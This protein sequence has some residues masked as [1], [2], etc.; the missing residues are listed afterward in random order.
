MPDFEGLATYLLSRIRDIVPTLLPGGRLVGSEYECASINGGQGKSFKININT[1]KWADFAADQQ[2]GDIISLYA[3]IHNI[4]QS[5]A[6]LQL[7]K[8]YRYNA[9]VV[10][11]EPRMWHPKHG[12][13]AASWLYRDRSGESLCYVARYN[14]K[15]GKEFMPW[16][17]D[18]ERWNAKAPLEPRPL[19]GLEKLRGKPVLIVEGEKAADAARQLLGE[20]YDVVTWSGGAKAYR[21]ADWSPIFGAKSVLLWPDADEPGILAMNGVADIVKG[22]VGQVKVLDV[23][24]QPKGWDVADALADGMT[25]SDVIAW[26]KPRAQVVSVS[27]PVA[28]LLPKPKPEPEP[29]QTNEPEPYHEPTPKPEPTIH[30]SATINAPQITIQ[31]DDLP[32]V[33]TESNVVLWDRLGI[34]CTGQGN[35]IMNEDNVARI[36]EGTPELARTLWRDVFY[37]AIMV[38]DPQTGPRKWVDEDTYRLTMH[39]QRHYGMSRLTDAIV[40]RAITVLSGRSTKNEPKDW[41]ESLTWD[42]TPRIEN[43]LTTHLGAQASAYTISASKNFWISIIARIY[44][45]GCIMRTMIVLQG[46]QWTGKS[47]AFSIIGGKWY[48]EVL[49]SIDS[50][51]FLQSLQGKLLLEFADMSGLDRSDLNRI[52]QVISCRVDSFRAPYDRSPQDHPRQCVLVS[53]T[54]EGHFLRDDTG[55]TRFWPVEIGRID[56]NLIIRDRD[57][58]FAE[59]VARYKTGENWHIM[60]TEET[61]AVQEAYRQSDEWETEIYEWIK[62]NPY[63]TEFSVREI[64]CEC[65]K[66]SIDRLDKGSQIRIARNLKRIGCERFQ[67]FTDGKNIKLWRRGDGFL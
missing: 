59:A 14:T 33:P 65:L 63:R 26:A 12:T 58:L 28:E 9:P 25:T 64:G 18:G 52:K 22:T 37:R 17:W 5:E 34:A 4:K 39:L 47:T 8:N 55:G 35:P 51:N 56:H 24:D 6:A 62:N 40:R 60:P 10:K 32:A 46:K 54:N 13:P 50:N 30:I 38:N 16:T 48:A 36:F 1:G 23:S 29:E 57:Q 67:N 45:P 2:G 15:D 20:H 27:S 11:G 3:A 41:M 42:G 66:I 43:F 21:K 44:D 19:Y 7:A 31:T 49:E 53:T 61:E